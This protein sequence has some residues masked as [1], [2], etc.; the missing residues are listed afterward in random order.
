MPS[1]AEPQPMAGR[2]AHGGIACAKSNMTVRCHASD[3]LVCCWGARGVG[4]GGLVVGVWVG[5]EEWGGGKKKEKKGKVE[6]I[7]YMGP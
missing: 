3:V 2:T 6:E 1:L 5:V 7:T 4:V